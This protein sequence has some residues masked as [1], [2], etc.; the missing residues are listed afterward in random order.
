[1]PYRIEVE[2]NETEMEPDEAV[3]VVNYLGEVLEIMGYSYSINCVK[4]KDNVMHLESPK[5][6]V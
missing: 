6:V 3:S 2:L 4:G 5:V 1:M